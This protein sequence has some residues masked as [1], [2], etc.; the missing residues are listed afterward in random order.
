ME[1]KN[2]TPAISIII[3]LY[4]SEK[5][6]RECIESIFV[7]TFQN[8]EVII[9]DDCSTDKSREI[10]EKSVAEFFENPVEKI[11]LIELEKNSGGGGIPRNT[12]IKAARGKYIMFIDSDDLISPTALEELYKIAEELDADILSVKRFYM[13]RGSSLKKAR[14]ISVRGVEIKNPVLVQDPIRSYSRHI[15]QP[16]PWC[17]FFKRDFIVQNKIE[18]PDFLVSEDT[19]F[20]IYSLFFAKKVYRI[21]NLYYYYRKYSASS[22]ASIISPADFVRKRVIATINGTKL[23]EDFDEKFE[24]F[25]D[26]SEIKYRVISR[27]LGIMESVLKRDM[28]E[29]ISK[30]E[31]I[32]IVQDVYDK[33]GEQKYLPIVL[34]C[35]VN[36]LRREILTKNAEIKE[37]QEQINSLQEQLKTLQEKTQTSQEQTQ[38]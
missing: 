30:Q 11:R 4:N 35:R 22:T 10:V 21:P 34:F 18:F 26:K 19:F 32:E 5:F 25:K 20:L 12:G 37:L 23:L 14:K 38:E 16:M 2:F 3:P 29:K 7:Q 6:I 27:I 9:V 33:V 31:F 17:Y 13:F 24:V 1:I 36:E 8:Y 15:F 28:D